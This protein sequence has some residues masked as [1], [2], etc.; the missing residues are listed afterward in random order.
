MATK[1][2]RSN[3]VIST[4]VDAAS[5]VITFIVLRGGAN[6]E[7]ARFPFDPK[8]VGEANIPRFLLNGIKQRVVDT[9]AL[10]KDQSNGKA[11][12]P[13]MKAE[14]IKRIV[15]HY[16]S[17]SEEWSPAR[18]DGG[19]VLDSVLVAAVAEGM[20][21]TPEDTKA[22]VIKFA[23]KKGITPKEYLAAAASSDRIVGIVARMRQERTGVT[24]D[25]MLAEMEEGAE[26]EGD[27]DKS[28]E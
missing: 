16:M 2:I 15:D 7:N 23:E 17:G 3:A 22:K 6:G 1:A 21:W 13:Q 8:R 26:G 24:A 9:A 27:E 11:A 5:G 20:G 12:T 19:L 18:A 10:D 4:E 25:D 14:R 28:E